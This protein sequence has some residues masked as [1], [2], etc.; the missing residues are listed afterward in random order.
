MPT[1]GQASPAEVDDGSRGADL[2]PTPDRPIT[3]SR[4]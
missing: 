4:R 1:R 2:E 3:A